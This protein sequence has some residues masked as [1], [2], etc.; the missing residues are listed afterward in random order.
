MRLYEITLLPCSAL[1]TPLAGDT[2]FG[3]FCWQAAYDPGLLPGGLEANLTRYPE[4]PFAVFSSAWPRFT[5]NGRVTYAVKRPDLPLDRLAPPPAGSRSQRL[6]HRKEVKKKSWLLVA[7]DLRLD[8]SRLADDLTLSELLLAQAPPVIKRLCRRAGA[9]QPLI[10]WEQPHNTINRQT[11]TT[12]KELFAPYTQ[13]AHFY[14]PETELA[15]FVLLDEAATDLDRVCRGL[16]RIGQTGFG[17]DASIGLGR[18]KLTGHRE[19]P[20]PQVPGAD[21]LFT[22]APCVP[23][24]HSFSEAFFT[25][26]VRF[27]KHGDRLATSKN[28]FKAP[29]VMAAPGAVFMPAEPQALTR[30]Y[31]GRAVT[32]V[33]LVQP[34]AVVQGYAPVLP[35]PLEVHH[36]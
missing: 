19:L 31:F 22:L 17:K 1:G 28:P 21:A 3:Q 34:Q 2:L 8:P 10:P 12:G 13:E 9:Q 16:T 14:F 30:P 26:L 35:F 25:P 27:G 36:A 32:G 29:V 6:L 11:L 24:P 4:A 23:P 18:F 33:S 5:Q 15:L 20:L 7:E